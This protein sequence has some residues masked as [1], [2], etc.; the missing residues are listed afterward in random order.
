MLVAV[1]VLNAFLALSPPAADTDD[2]RG[3]PLREIHA[4]RAT[5]AN[6]VLVLFI[7]GDGGWAALDRNVVAVLADHGA[8]IVGMDSRAYLATLRKPD[9]VGRDVTRIV[10][11]YMREWHAQRI[12]LAGYSRGADLMP[13]AANRLPPDLARR[14]SLIALLGFATRVGFEFHWQD[15]VRTV[16]RPG[17]RLTIPEVEKLRGTRMLCVYGVEEKES[18]C[19]AASPGL[20]QMVAL[21]GKHHFDNNYREL[22]EL[23]WKALIT[24]ESAPEGARAPRPA[25]PD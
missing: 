10:R 3:L 24:P 7:T 12:V 11:H 4:T 16:R 14:V 17:D 20:M 23:I 18:G 21:P 2:L 1:A 25:S 5:P 22:G 19:V 15:I 8:N 6:D 9:E 13:F